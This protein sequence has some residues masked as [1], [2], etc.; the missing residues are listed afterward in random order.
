MSVKTFSEN[1]HT[2]IENLKKE[3]VV[4]KILKNVTEI[5]IL[6]NRDNYDTDSFKGIKKDFPDEFEILEEALNT[7]ASEK[8]L[9]NIKIEVPDK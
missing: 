7:Y 5:V 8:H 2:V 1:N 6:L 9:E 4:D 3:N